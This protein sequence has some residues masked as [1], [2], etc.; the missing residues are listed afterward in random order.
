MLNHTTNKQ[1]FYRFYHPKRSC[2]KVMFSQASV[3]LFRGV[4]QTPLWAD[5]PWADTPGQ[6]PPW[7][8]TPQADTSRQT[9]PSQTPGRK[10]LLR[11]VRILL[12][13]ILVYFMLY[14]MF[15]F[16]LENHDEFVCLVKAL[17][18]LRDSGDKDLFVPLPKEV[19]QRNLMLFIYF[20]IFWYD[21]FIVNLQSLEL[22]T[23]WR[24]RLLLRVHRW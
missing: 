4:W 6:I 20:F 9:P 15:F 2:S 17:V 7:V 21:L 1:L 3:T 19:R 16:R 11:T 8:D 14:R 12:E 18:A 22:E 5:T 24:K 10:L 23:H 13:C